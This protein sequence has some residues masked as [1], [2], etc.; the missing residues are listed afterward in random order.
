[1]IMVSKHEIS[2]LL[3]S[4]NAAYFRVLPKD[5]IGFIQGS[6]LC[7]SVLDNTSSYSMLQSSIPGT[8]TRKHRFTDNA[9]LALASTLT[10]CNEISVRS[11]MVSS[12]CIT[13]QFQ[14]IL[15]KASFSAWGS[16]KIGQTFISPRVNWHKI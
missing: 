13:L 8:W 15:A 3:Q 7:S 6:G 16:V 1:M 4:I 12:T 14:S 11:S 2:C 10:R 5:L 9:I